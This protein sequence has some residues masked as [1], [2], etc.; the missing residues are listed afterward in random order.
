M[1]GRVI[2]DNDKRCAVNT[3]GD[4]IAKLSSL[5][6]AATHQLLLRLREFDALGGWAMQGART[7]AEC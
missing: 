5:I 2:P 1:S 6:N 4:E 3:L 7:Y